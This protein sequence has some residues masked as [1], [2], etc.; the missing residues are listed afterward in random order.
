LLFFPHYNMPYYFKFYENNDD[1]EPSFTCAVRSQRCEGLNKNGSRCARKCVIGTPYC[2][3]HLL[4]KFHLRI[5]PSTMPEA[6]KG[7][8]VLDKKQPTG[9]VLIKKDQTV[10]PYGGDLIDKATLDERYG[11]K[12][13]PYAVQLSKNRF[14]DGGCARGVGSLLNHDSR[15]ANVA[16]SVNQN[17]KTVSIKATR[18]LKNGEELFVNYGREY[19]MRDGS[20]YVTISK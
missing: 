12:T 19:Q 20:K 14:R 2:W 17:A 1:P 13:A 9:T 10:C 3:T 6:G 18:N 16:F 15:R 11:D 5:L 7:L 8:F 4:A